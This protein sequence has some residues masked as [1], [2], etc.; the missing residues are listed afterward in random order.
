MRHRRRLRTGIV[1]AL[2]LIGGTTLGVLLPEVDAGPTI[3]RTTV[4]PMLFGAAGGFISFIA[5]V[6]SLLFLVIQYGNTSVSPRLTI[7]RDDPMVWHTF[8]FF[9]AVFAY[10]LV[11][12]MITGT[13]DD[14]VTI[15]VPAVAITLLVASLAMSRAIQLRALRLLQFNSIME[16]VRTRGQEVITSL[17]K[18]AFHSDAADQAGP[19][20]AWELRW[21]RPTTLLLQVDL[22]RLLSLATE[23]DVLIELRAVPG[24][25]VRRG[26]VLAVV[27]ADHPVT[28]CDILGALTTGSDR[29]FAQ[30]PLLAFRLLNDISNRALSISINDPATCV[31]VLGCIYDLLAQVADKQLQLGTI[32]DESGVA[33]VRLPFPSWEDFLVVGVDEVAHYSTHD[34][35]VHAR[36]ELLLQDLLAI[37]PPERHAPLRE[38]LDR[39]L[40]TPT[41]PRA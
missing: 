26:L 38:R 27:R 11:A 1:Q 7:F 40:A 14:T 3:E 34:P 29:A 36:V 37:A 32:T 9:T 31:Q 5:L 16:E 13:G 20:T 24:Q 35:T 30:D 8:G 2:Y 23:M 39:L 41:V 21:Q 28:E 25:E 6:F 12:G 4:T 33:R 22:P 19:P 18:T 10:C 15:L 17:Y